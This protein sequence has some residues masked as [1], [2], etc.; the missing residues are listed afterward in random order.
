MTKT[1][2]KPKE[3]SGPGSDAANFA[4]NDHPC[5]IAEN[6]LVLAAKCMG[7]LAPPPKLT[8]SE[9]ADERRMLP[10]TSAE[11]GRWRTDRTPYLR[12]V[13]DACSDPSVKKIVLMFAS[14]LGK[15]E[16]LLNIAGYFMD[17]DPAAMLIIQPTVEMAEAFSKE[18]LAP[19]LTDT[20]SLADKVSDPRS[21][22][23][24]NT[25]LRKEYPGGYIVL[26]GANAPAG[27][28]SR[29][30]RVVL[31]DEVD[32][33]PISAG[34]EGDPLSLAEKRTTTF[35]NSLLVYDSTPT[36]KGESRIEAEYE[37]ST[38]EQWCVPCPSCGELQPYEWGRLD[39]EEEA[40]YCR[41]CGAYHSEY[42]WKAAPGEWIARQEHATT[43]G[44]HMNAMASPWLT[45]PE[46]I[47]EFKE[48]KTKGPEVLKTFIN[49]RLAECWEE[50][51]EALDENVLEQRRHSYGCDVPEA[52]QWITCGVDVQKDRLELEIVGWGE[53]K[54]SWGIE[55]LILM[56]NPLESQVWTELDTLLQ[57]T[58]QREDGK[59]LPI[60]CTA[61]DSGNM[62]SAVY[63]FTRP[64]TFRYI[65][66]IKGVFGPGKPIV[67]KVSRVGRQRN[68][69][70][71]PVGVDAAKDLIHS[72]LMVED[73]AGCTHYP[74]ETELSNG[75]LR[76][77]D[78]AYFKGMMEEKRVAQMVKGRPYFIWKK[79]SSHSRNEPW[80]CRVYATAALE[81][82]NP[83]MLRSSAGTGVAAPVKK[84]TKRRARG[85]LSKG[86]S[87]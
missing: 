76:G 19:M 27:L 77:Y 31:S 71:F 50:A 82:S 62:T 15:T 3:K 86:V 74:L 55:Y 29:P 39:F 8:V 67:D 40:M 1:L 24:S 46:L 23:S 6:T 30:I 48:A 9:W 51:G 52:V 37:E 85:V 5:E 21:R 22:D 47:T 32:R 66:A 7:L 44:F 64:R 36:V 84:A 10:K 28:A 35:W 78:K 60:S 16:C 12:E 75:R 17:Y 4:R 73:G 53:G 43:R 69:P 20:P 26:I 38:Q 13:M 41:D 11:P 2:S 81:I 49:T 87:V 42:E 54:E 25:I 83:E 33:Y 68:V 70:L 59:L 80:D 18:R 45:W 58:Y 63:A 14:Q 65:F 34:S 57:R 79:R 56:G 61:V 72:R